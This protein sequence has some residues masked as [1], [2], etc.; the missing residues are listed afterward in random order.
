M[1]RQLYGFLVKRPWLRKVVVTTPAIRDMAWRFVAGED[2]DAGLAAVRALN[3]RGIRGTLN[4]V[5]THVRSE[6]EAVAAADA[7]VEALRRIRQ[8]GL[9]SHLS[10]KLTQLGLDLDVALCRAQVRRVLGCARE[11]GNFVRID[12]EE[13]AY[14]EATLRLFEAVR[15]FYGADTVGIAVQSYLRRRRGD[16]ERLLAGGSRVRLVKGGYW[17]SAAVAYQRRDD[18]DRAFRA[19]LDLLLAG[20][21]QPAV[22]THDVRFIAQARRTAAASR[23]GQRGFEF[24]M[25][26]GVRRDLQERLVRQGYTVRCYVPYGRQ[27]YGYFLGC[28]RRVPGGVLRRFSEWARRDDPCGAGMRSEGRP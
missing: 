4:H 15:E 27:W 21:R 13:S 5:G 14:T 9:E 18:I 7:A 20:G 19:D 1:L 11:L 25:L 16:L 23:L 3:A 24:Q 17:E 22:A 2:L 8:E 28:A 10:I 26:Y 12:M 6:A